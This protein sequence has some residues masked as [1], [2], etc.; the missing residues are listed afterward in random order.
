MLVRKFLTK[1]KTVI[2]P[3]PPYLP[4]MTPA[5]VLLIPQL[6]TP[7]KGRFFDTIEEVKE[8]LKQDLLAIPK[9]RVSEVFRELQKKSPKIYFSF[10]NLIEM[11]D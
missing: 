6:K 9:N 10:F 8:K 3:P 1:N 4:L 11:S 2:M 7:I 5:D